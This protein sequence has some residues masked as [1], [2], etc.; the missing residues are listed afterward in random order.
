MGSKSQ[1]R[2]GFKHHFLDETKFV[3]RSIAGV[4]M[5]VATRLSVEAKESA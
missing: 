2:A 3:A 1:M 4:G 5:P